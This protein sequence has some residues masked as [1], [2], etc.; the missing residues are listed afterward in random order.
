LRKTKGSSAG[1]A[2]VQKQRDETS[3]DA[4]PRADFGESR[5][6]QARRASKKRRPGQ[7]IAD[8]TVE[9]RDA[10][11]PPTL[12]SQRSTLLTIRYS[13]IGPDNTPLG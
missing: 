10:F 3:A 5:S 4:R 9:L 2:I 13:L 8:P 11:V 7:L 1:A 6:L 12:L